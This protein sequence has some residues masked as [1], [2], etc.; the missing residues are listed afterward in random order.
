MK[1]M[2]VKILFDC[3][4]VRCSQESYRIVH[5]DS[6]LLSRSRLGAKSYSRIR[7]AT[8]NLHRTLPEMCEGRC[9][10]PLRTNEE[11]Y[12]AF[13]HVSAITTTY[14]QPQ[15]R[16]DY[17]LGQFCLYSRLKIHGARTI[18]P[19]TETHCKISVRVWS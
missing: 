13:R 18:V 4:L 9:L 10:L 16:G 14:G 12:S 6:S 17:S 11:F 5:F 2:G 7:A 19:T 1:T 8:M 15:P 3:S